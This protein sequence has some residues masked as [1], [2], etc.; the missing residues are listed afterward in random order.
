LKALVETAGAAAALLD[1]RSAATATDAPA[2]R[3]NIA[4][5][6]FFISLSFLFVH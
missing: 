2:T 6:S 1:G 5:I 3:A 4:I